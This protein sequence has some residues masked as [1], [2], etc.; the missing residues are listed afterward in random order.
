MSSWHVP[1]YRRP[2]A[3]LSQ[4]SLFLTVP[5]VVLTVW[6]TSAILVWRRGWPI[7]KTQG[8]RYDRWAWPFSLWAGLFLRIVFLGL[9]YVLLEK[10]TRRLR[11]LTFAN[12]LDF[13]PSGK[14]M[15]PPAA[16]VWH[17]FNKLAVGIMVLY[18]IALAWRDHTNYPGWALMTR[19]IAASFLIEIVGRIIV[20]YIC[21][22]SGIGLPTL[23]RFYER[24]FAWLN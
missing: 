20:D 12:S 10:R 9:D 17:Q 5:P 8:S 14:P 7:I 18:S 4:K 22:S 3:Y 2:P 16:Q 1:Q 13:D 15:G 19:W 24:F 23:E 6:I 11:Y 21:R